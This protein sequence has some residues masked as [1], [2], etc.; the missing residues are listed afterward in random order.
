MEYT[1]LRKLPFTSAMYHKHVDIRSR[2]PTVRIC[3]RVCT[4]VPV[5]VCVRAYVYVNAM[6]SLA[7]TI[8]VISV[9]FKVLFFV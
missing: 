9:A 7:I 8:S 5:Y 4:C 3:E 2:V 6:L 1:K